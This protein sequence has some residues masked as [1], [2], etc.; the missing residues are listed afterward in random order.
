MASKAIPAKVKRAK[1]KGNDVSFDG[2]TW[3]VNG[4]KLDRYK[5]KRG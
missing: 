4:E 3:R 2:K 1:A 5:R